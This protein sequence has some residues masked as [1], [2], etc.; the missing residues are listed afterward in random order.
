MKSALIMTR[1]LDFLQKKYNEGYILEKRG[2]FGEWQYYYDPKRIYEYVWLCFNQGYG[3]RLWRHDPL[4]PPDS[5]SK[6][7]VGQ[8][9][10]DKAFA[11]EDDIT[12]KWNSGVEL[13]RITG[14]WTLSEAALGPDVLQGSGFM[15]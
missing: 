3:P 5:V 8:W 15:K 7:D 10:R 9:F 4:M 12:G 11:I 14:E 13:G 6:V 1:A 2:K